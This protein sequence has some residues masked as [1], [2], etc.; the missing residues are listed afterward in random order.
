MILKVNETRQEVYSSGT[1]DGI[2]VNVLVCANTV[3]VPLVSSDFNPSLVSTKCTL[4]REGRSIDIISSNLLLNGVFSTLQSKYHEFINGYDKVY[5]SSS[6][7]AVKLR[8]LFIPFTGS[9][10][11]NK[12]DELIVELSCPNSGAFSSNVDTNLSSIQFYVNPSIGY[13]LFV[14]QIKHEVVTSSTP[15]QSFNLGNNITRIG[16]INLDKN[17]LVDEVINQLSL[18]SD[19]YDLNLN[20]N[21]LLALNSQNYGVMPNSRYG[22]VLPISATDLT[23]RAL[24]GLDYNPQS[25]IIF[26]GVSKASELQGSRLSLNFNSANVGTSQN[27]ISYI[28]YQTTK[29]VVADAIVR[30]QKHMK[31]KINDTPSK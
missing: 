31:E 22:S 5:A 21:Q 9:I 24:R 2:F 1:Y 7:K 28:T 10:R 16:F 23:G 25:M 14:P 11:I 4:K 6:V 15:E 8:T 20:F 12:G 19:Y 3:N 29:Q 26:D 27:Y 30:E 18:T 17:T 13:E